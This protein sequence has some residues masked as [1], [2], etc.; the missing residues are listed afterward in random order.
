M[1]GDD[2]FV[3]GNKLKYSVSTLEDCILVYWDFSQ[4]IEILRKYPEHYVSPLCAAPRS[5]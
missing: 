1:F 5:L 4:F 3:Y 2:N